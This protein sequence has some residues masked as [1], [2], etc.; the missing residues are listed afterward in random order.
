MTPPNRAKVQLEGHCLSKK[1][2]KRKLKKYCI[3]VAYSSCGLGY[4]DLQKIF[5][6]TGNQLFFVVVKNTRVIVF[7]PQTKQQVNKPP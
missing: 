2:Q 5:S 6:S 1:A 7:L 3:T 4:C